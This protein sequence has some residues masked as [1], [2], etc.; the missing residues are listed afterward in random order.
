MN[1]YIKTIV[2]AL[3]A[4]MVTSCADPE[5]SPIITFD[6]A[7]KGAYI[8]L[9]ELKSGLFDNNSP[10]TAALEFDAEFI[11]IENGALVNNYS[12][13][14]QYIDANPDNG[15]N[16]V[17]TTP[18][19]S[20]GKSDFGTSVNGKVGMSLSISLKDLTTKLGLNLDDIL[21]L[22]QFRF[23]S[24]IT[25]DDGQV[26]SQANSSAAVT[27]DAF[28]GWFNFSGIVTCP[29]PDD[30]FSGAY[31]MTYVGDATTAFG[32]TP[33]GPDPQTVMLST[34]TGSKTQR[35]ISGDDFEG[36][37][38]L[39]FGLGPMTQD[40]DLLCT[41]SRIL[42]TDIGLGCG[43]RIDY[44][45]GSQPDGTFDFDDDSEFI[46]NITFNQAQECGAAPDLFQIKLTKQ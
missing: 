42:P 6:K 31:T 23:S 25:L 45:Q 20:F 41:V 16:S 17:A 38:E 21:A 4:F 1:K 28:Q 46:L 27:G 2:I 35:R 19:L 11:D 10:E 34:I 36:I 40:F 14:V 3:G 43:G 26:F 18:Y 33:Y 39:G 12:I 22:D 8:R 24:S 15:D 13:N 9:V 32:A 30:R 7:G 44:V 37:P 5:L 29:I